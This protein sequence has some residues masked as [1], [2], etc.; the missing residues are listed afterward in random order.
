MR[1]DLGP[2]AVLRNPQ[3]RG[4]ARIALRKFNR[5]VECNLDDLGGE[6]EA[7]KCLRHGWFSIQYVIRSAL[8]RPANDRDE[9]PARPQF[10]ESGD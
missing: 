8:D 5:E 3:L 6:A 4:I 2:T 9:A 10:S 1:A 7:L